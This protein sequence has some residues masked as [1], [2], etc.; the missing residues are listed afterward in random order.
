MLAGTAVAVAGTC[1]VPGWPQTLSQPDPVQGSSRPGAG[2]AVHS[3][4]VS[5]QASELLGITGQ[6]PTPPPAQPSSR[7]PGQAPATLRDWAG[8]ALKHLEWEQVEAE[9]CGEQLSPCGD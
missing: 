9:D 3:T 7:D 6:G 2:A 4:S 8:P 1:P 5:G